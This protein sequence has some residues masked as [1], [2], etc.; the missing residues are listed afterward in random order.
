MQF[1]RVLICA[2]AS[3]G[4]S[5]QAAASDSSAIG[6]PNIPYIPWSG[7]VT[8]SD[9]AVLPGTSLRGLKAAAEL[10]RRADDWWC[11]CLWFC[12]GCNNGD[13]GHNCPCTKCHEECYSIPFTNGEF[14]DPN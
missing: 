13:S 6:I 7:T 5:A 11:D 14:A 2:A 3:V 10:A 12:A 1:I 8:I 4:I 9:S